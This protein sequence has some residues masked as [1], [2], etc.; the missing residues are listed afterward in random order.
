MIYLGDD[1]TDEDAFAALPDGITI[2]VGHAEET[3]AKF[4]VA[5]PAEVQQFLFWLNERRYHE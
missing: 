1:F 3:L 2:K 4:H 5:N